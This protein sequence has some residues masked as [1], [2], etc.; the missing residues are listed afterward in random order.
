MQKFGL[1]IAVVLGVVMISLLVIWI[2]FKKK[3]YLERI[4]KKVH[5][6]FP[7]KSENR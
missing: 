5:I 6:H 7:S 4:A 3:V 1:I 2:I